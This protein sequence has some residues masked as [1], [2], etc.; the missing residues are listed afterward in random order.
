MFANKADAKARAIVAL[1]AVIK[2]VDG[3]SKQALYLGHFLP[4]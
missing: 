1:F 4:L 2:I 3:G